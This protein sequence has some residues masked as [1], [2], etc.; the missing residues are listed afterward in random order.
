M[1]SLAD[2][3]RLLAVLVTVAAALGACQSVAGSHPVPS[4]SQIGSDLKCAAGDSGFEDQVAGWG[5][6][7]P[8]SWKYNERSQDS[9]TPPGLDLTFDITDVPCVLP[10][11]GTSGGGQPVCSPGAGL[12]AFMIIS[13]YQR[14][15]AASL[16]AWIAAN[17]GATQ[18]FQ[19]ITWGNS[20]EAVR[21]PAGR[22]LALTPSHVVVMALHGGSGNLDLEA[23]MSTRLETWTF[24]Y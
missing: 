17:L 7:H 22:R 10:S 9:A 6:C 5:F 24:T 13:T 1:R 2:T 19:P 3:A 14:G 20:L 15:N 23:Q 12:F 16:G 11:A 8:G 18:S 4:V 21:L